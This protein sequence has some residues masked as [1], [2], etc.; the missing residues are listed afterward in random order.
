MGSAGQADPAGQ[1]MDGAV[2]NAANAAL[3]RRMLVE[4]KGLFAQ[5]HGRPYAGAADASLLL[6]PID[7]PNGVAHEVQEEA[8]D[9]R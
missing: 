3:V 7:Q 2:H 8:P 4:A 1:G 9:A 6:N 5:V